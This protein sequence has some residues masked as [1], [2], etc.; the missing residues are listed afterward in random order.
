MITNKTLEVCA[1]R[2][3]LDI[4]QKIS[5]KPGYSIELEGFELR[6][7]RP[8][9]SYVSI[10]LMGSRN[11]RRVAHFNNGKSESLNNLDK[12][13]R[14]MDLRKN[15]NP[16]NYP[17]WYHVILTE[18]VEVSVIKETDKSLLVI[19]TDI[20]G[21]MT[22]TRVPKTSNYFRNKNQALRKVAERLKDQVSVYLNL[23][24]CSE[25]A[26]D[27]FLS[28]NPGIEDENEND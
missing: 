20:F 28:D 9:G 11:S 4:L 18:I 19:G 15:L 6:L 22:E 2:G 23:L 14:F 17:T 8:D 16:K 26:L 10:D 3:E 24:Q 7:T 5:K 25:R 21:K 13:E 27:K 12:L 1:H